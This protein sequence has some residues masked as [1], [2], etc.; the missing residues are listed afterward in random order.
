MIKR[1]GVQVYLSEE[2]YQLCDKGAKYYADLLEIVY[3]LGYTY[4]SETIHK[5]YEDGYSTT[6]IAAIFKHNHKSIW[7]RLRTM[8]IVM[9]PRGNYISSKHKG[10]RKCR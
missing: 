5:L 2:Y 8:G 1:E 7:K 3:K 10:G 9:N 4:F 6:A